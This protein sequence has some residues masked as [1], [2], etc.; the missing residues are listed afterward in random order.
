MTF[1]V[2]SEVGR[3]RQVLLHRPDLALKRLTPTNKDE[4]LFDD[5]LWVQR[6][7]EEHEEFQQVLRERGVTVHILGD[8]LR[9]TVEIPEARKHIL[10]AVVDER[11]LGP[12]AVDDIRNTLDALDSASLQTYLTGGVTKRELVELGCDPKSVAFHA[13]HD[14][15]FVLPPLPNH[16]FTRDPSCWIYDGVSVNAMRK[17]ARM[18]ETVNMEAVYQFHPTFAEGFDR[19]QKDGYHVW[20]PGHT[21]APATLEGGDVLVIGRG[22]VLVGMSERTQPQAVEMLA[23]HLFQAGSVRRIVALDMPK[24]RAFMHL[25]TVMTM[26]DADV[27]TKYAG[28]GM[29]PSYTIEP[30]DTEKELK[31]TDHPP[32][33]MHRAIA[34]ALDL[35]DIKVLTPTQDVYAAEREQWDDGCNALAVEPGVVI[36][37]ERNTTTNNFLRANGVEVITIRGS[38]LGRGRGGPR[39]MSCPLE[40]DGV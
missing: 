13:L 5:V 22:A 27:F 6:A 23:R 30:G 26:V 39:C 12:L 18:R 40:R 10:D 35:D 34:R 17:K 1:H 7:V 28:L 37:Y 29:L 15:G 19:P 38:E 4:F 14:D 11:F 21:I 9:E 8:L 20:L 31:V 25:D 32:E 33:D 3:L 24:A 16:L 36:A 2:D